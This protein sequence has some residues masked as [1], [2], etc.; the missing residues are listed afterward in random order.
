MNVFY[1]EGFNN[2]Y[3]RELKAYDKKNV[4]YFDEWIVKSEDNKNYNPNDNVNTT[5]TVNYTNTIPEYNIPDTTEIDYVL[6]SE[7]GENIDSKWFVIDRKRERKGQWVLSLRRDLLSDFYDVLVTSPVY[8]EKGWLN[9]SNKLIYNSENMTYNQIKKSEVLLKDE[10]D[11]AWIV[12]YIGNDYKNGLDANGTITFTRNI[13]RTPILEFSYS[14]LQELIDINNGKIYSGATMNNQ[15]LRF[16]MRFTRYDTGWTYSQTQYRTDLGSGYGLGVAAIGGNIYG[17]LFCTDNVSITGNS[18]A[19]RLGDTFVKQKRYFI[20]TATMDNYIPGYRSYIEDLKALNGQY[21]KNTDSTGPAYFSVSFV[22]TDA[23]IT[24]QITP[25]V[26]SSV[27]ND[28][29]NTIYNAINYNGDTEHFYWDDSATNGFRVDVPVSKYLLSVSTQSPKVTAQTKLIN[30]DGTAKL[31]LTDAPYTMFCMPYKDIGVYS[32]NYFEFGSEKTVCLEMASAISTKFGGGTNGTSFIYDLQLLPYCPIP[33]IMDTSGRINL[34]DADEGTWAWITSEDE[35]GQYPAVN[36]CGIIL[37]AATSSFRKSITLSSPITVPS[38][39]LEFKL[40]NETKFC[41]LVSPN[42]SGI[43]EFSPTQNQGVTEIEINCTYKPYK[44]YIHINPLFNTGSLFG[45]D[46]NDNRGL[47]CGGDFSLP[48]TTDAWTNFQ[49]QNRSY[50]QAHLRQIENLKINNAVQREKEVISAITGG[51]SGSISGATSG[52][53][54]GSAGGPVGSAIGAGV[55]FAT[56][57]AGNIYGG[58]KDIELNDRLRAE[59]IDFTKDMFGYQLQNIQ[60]MPNSMS[61]TSAFDID[62]KLFPFIEFYDCTDTEKQALTEKIRYNGMT[63]MAIGTINQYTDFNK[64]YIKGQL[65]KL[66]DS[67]GNSTGEMHETVEIASELM[68]GVYI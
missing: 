63:V 61:R 51:I 36:N 68:K 9:A 42:Y 23:S 56:S 41:R 53:L 55:G 6:V 8:I 20:G 32:A 60:A 34:T 57:L 17:N 35:Q 52:A 64:R 21:V 54:A 33:N 5:L 28:I 24:Y 7:D 58:I 50:E 26:G 12:G 14:E 44:P 49:I 16:N 13:D 15:D 2:Y 37:F 59:G 47:I 1:L 19:K 45:G 25:P 62:N 31:A 10:T 67:Q 4:S 43:F 38:D 11:S 3:N 40:D 39:A 48:Q 29:K 27:Y 18:A 65:I 46:F 22:Q 30:S 66:L